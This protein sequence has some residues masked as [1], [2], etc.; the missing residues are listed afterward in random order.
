MAAQ[1]GMCEALSCHG[2]KPVATQTKL[3]LFHPHHIRQRNKCRIHLIDFIKNQGKFPIFLFYFATVR[4]AFDGFQ[5]F[6]KDFN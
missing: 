5:H 1:N 3:Q 4:I 2:F 6:A